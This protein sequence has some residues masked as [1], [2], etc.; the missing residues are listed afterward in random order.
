MRVPRKAAWIRFETDPEFHFDFFLAERLRMPVAELQTRIT[1]DEWVAW[2]VYYG[3][4]AQDRELAKAR[5]A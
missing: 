1:M 4:Q 2:S 5:G 3:R